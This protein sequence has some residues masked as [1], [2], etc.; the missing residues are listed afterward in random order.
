MRHHCEDKE[1][2]PEGMKPGNDMNRLVFYNKHNQ[3]LFEYFKLCWRKKNWWGH[4]MEVK[5]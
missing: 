5:V 4:G 2:P 3:A 1:L